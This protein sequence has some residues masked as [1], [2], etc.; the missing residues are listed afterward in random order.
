MLVVA[1]GG[2]SSTESARLLSMEL[3]MAI[4]I[5]YFD[6]NSFSSQVQK[7]TSIRP[8]FSTGTFP[9]HFSSR[10]A[11]CKPLRPLSSSLGAQVTIFSIK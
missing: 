2:A 3:T 6:G 7:Y 11:K 8:L 1:I 9:C 4:D 10:V 5:A